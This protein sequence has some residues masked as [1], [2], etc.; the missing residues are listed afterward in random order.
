MSEKQQRAIIVWQYM[1]DCQFDVFSPGEIA[2]Y[3]F[4]SRYTSGNSTEPAYEYA[5]H[6]LRDLHNAGVVEKAVFRGSN[7]SVFWLKEKTK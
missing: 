6:A 2:R 5:K 7:Q 4:G 3:C 1:I